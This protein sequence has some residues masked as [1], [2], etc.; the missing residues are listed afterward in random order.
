MA[1]ISFS[2][3]PEEQ[4]VVAGWAFRQVLDDIISQHP[5]DAQLRKHFALAKD[6]KYLILY[7]EEPELSA[8]IT[9]AIWETITA[10]LSGTARS[11]IHDQPYGESSAEQYHQALQQLLETIPRSSSAHPE[12]EPP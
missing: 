8:K 6:L 1:V 10:I 2:R 4:W 7:M 3:K 12:P 9:N 5:R 11:G